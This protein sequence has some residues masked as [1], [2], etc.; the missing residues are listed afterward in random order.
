MPFLYEQKTNSNKKKIQTTT[1]RSDGDYIYPV[2]KY[3]NH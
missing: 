2:V 1:T 3:V